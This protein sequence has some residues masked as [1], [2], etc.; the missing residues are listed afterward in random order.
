MRKINRITAIGVFCCL[1]FGTAVAQQKR[2]NVKEEKVFYYE[3][4]PSLYKRYLKDVQGN[5]LEVEDKGFVIA[6]KPQTLYKGVYKE[7]KAFDG[8]FK[9]EIVL[10]E[11]AL[12]N[13]YEQGVLKAQYS[14]DYLEKE[15]YAVPINYDLETLFED[16]KVKQGRVYDQGE[17]E[18]ILEILN[19]EDF[20]IKSMYLDLFGM[21]YFNRISFEL[22]GDTLIMKNLADQ[23]EVWV[24]KVG[25]EFHADFVGKGKKVMSAKPLITEV[26]KGTP[27]STRIV[28]KDDKG[29]NQ[30]FCFKRSELDEAFEYLDENDFLVGMFLQFP[31]VYQGSVATL[32]QAIITRFSEIKNAMNN[33]A[34]FAALLPFSNFPFD[35]SQ[36]VKMGMYDENGQ[37][38][39]E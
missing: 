4:V 2:E 34:S 21:H 31:V 23:S 37:F 11:I 3:D 33:V 9:E 17:R 30:E 22:V 15:D 19:Y 5:L 20:K 14:F 16:G 35:K 38:V 26:A 28:Y 27:L 8:F 24:K 13:Y 12:V 39:E 7:G 6:A 1:S 25:S 29:Q 18:T 10:S 32:F 36:V